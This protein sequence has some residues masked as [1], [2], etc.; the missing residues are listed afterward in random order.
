M[1]EFKVINEDESVIFNF[2][3]SVN[4]ISD[5][6]LTAIAKTINVAAHHSL[7]ALVCRESLFNVVTTLKQKKKEVTTGVIPIFI[8]HGET[9]SDYIKSLELKDRLIIPSSSLAMAY[10]VNTNYNTLSLDNF[11]RYA[12]DDTSIGMR[13]AAEKDKVCF[14]DF[15]IIG[16]NDIIG[17]YNKN[18]V[19]KDVY[20]QYARVEDE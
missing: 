4:E 1:K 2:P 19:S 5:E 8:S 20:S 6:Y 12:K 14:V 18:K 9:D 16:N 13:A 17:A 3:T 15:K 11:V 10:H 7:I